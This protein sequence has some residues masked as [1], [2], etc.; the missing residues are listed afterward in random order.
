MVPTSFFHCFGATMHEPFYM[1]KKRKTC[2]HTIAGHTNSCLARL[3]SYDPSATLR[4]RTRWKQMASLEIS[5]NRIPCFRC[6]QTK[7]TLFEKVFS[8]LL[9]KCNHTP[10]IPDSKVIT[11][12]KRNGT[13]IPTIGNSVYIGKRRSAGYFRHNN[14]LSESS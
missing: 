6:K 7:K 11:T 10:A 14:R 2:D 3:Y 8:L 9:N 4:R 12:A 1:L 13:A 5:F